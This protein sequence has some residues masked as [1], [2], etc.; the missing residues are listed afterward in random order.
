MLPA[1][2]LAATLTRIATADKPLIAAN[3]DKQQQNTLRLEVGQHVQGTVQAKVAADVFQVR[4][5]NQTVQMQLPAFVKPGDLIGLQ[6]VSLQP[7]LTFSFAASVNPLSTSEQLGSTARL[8]SSMS[9]QPVRQDYVPPVRREP[10]WLGERST[11]DTAQLAGRL[12]QSLSHSGLFYE[13]HQAQWVAGTR[14]TP[15]LMQEPQNQLRMAVTPNAQSIPQAPQ[16]GSPQSAALPPPT[17]SLHGEAAANRMPSIPEHLQPIVQQ[18]LHALENKQ[19]V[20]MGQA[21]PG[22]DIRWEVREEGPRNGQSDAPD[23]QW[24]TEL[25]LDLPQLGGVTARLSMNGNAVSLHLAVAD[26]Q[27]ARKMEQASA[28][29]VSSLTGHGIPVLQA[30]IEREQEGMR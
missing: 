1:D 5:A 3:P 2:L 11:P 22:Q 14:A 18:Q 9:Q 19:V 8:L 20:W 17:A 13:S 28:Q 12:H 15:Q 25:R 29:L 16:P 23:K 4:V 27:T 24:V 6:V 21:W 7:R 26:E 10:L 30:R